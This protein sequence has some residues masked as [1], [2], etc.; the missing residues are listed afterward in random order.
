MKVIAATGQS[1][2]LRKI[3]ISSQRGSFLSN[4]AE[5]RFELGDFE[6]QSGT[7]LPN[8]FL[9]YATHGTLN[10]ARDNVIV[11]P[12][13]YLGHHSGT[14]P[15]I[16]P[17]KAL[18]PERYFIIV[19]DMFTNGVS[20]SPSNCAPPFNGINFPL[21]TPFDNVVAQ[22]Q[23]LIEEFSITGVELAMGFSMSGAGTQASKKPG[24]PARNSS[25][26]SAPASR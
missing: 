1:H 7:I 4:A 2:R 20:S 26:V 9:G 3:S 13:W 18:D 12:T 19:P 21:V 8:A 24:A 5:G 23:L 14:E 22:Y 6:L 15:Y 11:Y 17:G 16:G 10:D 25:S